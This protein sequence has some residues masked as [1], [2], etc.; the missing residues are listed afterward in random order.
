[1]EQGRVVGEGR[2]T[3][4][5]T[6]EQVRRAYLGYAPTAGGAPA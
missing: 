1:M 5:L 2:A 4:L 3:D 6:D